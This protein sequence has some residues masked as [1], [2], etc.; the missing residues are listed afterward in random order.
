[1]KVLGTSGFPTALR[2]ARMGFGFADVGRAI[3]FG[4]NLWKTS[5]S[6][7]YYYGAE[8]KEPHVTERT[9]PTTVRPGRAAS[10]IAQQARGLP[11]MS[12]SDSVPS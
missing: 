11:P 12:C 6:T 5:T 8:I 10:Y 9:L 1:M 3:G 7:L 4:F 2:C